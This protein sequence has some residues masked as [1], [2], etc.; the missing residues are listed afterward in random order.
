MYTTKIIMKLII[1]HE[2][3]MER[4]IRLKTKKS[5]LKIWNSMD[6]NNKKI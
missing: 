1:N 4:K 3:K 6:S 5:S 2:L